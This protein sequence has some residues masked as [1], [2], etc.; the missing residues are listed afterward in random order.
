MVKNAI[1]LSLNNNDSKDNIDISMS[2]YDR[3]IAKT[4]PN[5]SCDK[6]MLNIAPKISANNQIFN[7]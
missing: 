5:L 4:E 2:K 6:R 3:S 7:A 1:N